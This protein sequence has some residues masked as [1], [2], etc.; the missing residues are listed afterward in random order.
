MSLEVVF[1]IGINFVFLRLSFLPEAPKSFSL[2]LVSIDSPMCT[3]WN[4]VY[5][6]LEEP[7]TLQMLCTLYILRK[8]TNPNPL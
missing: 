1:E 7:V 4:V 3:K 6:I 8:V 2:A 5:K